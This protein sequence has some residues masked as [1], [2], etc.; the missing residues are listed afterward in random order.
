[1]NHIV[2]WENDGEQ[3]KEVIVQKYPYLN[4]NPYWVAK[5]TEY[6]FKPS[7]TWTATSS[8][9]FGVRHSDAGFV[10]DVAGSSCFPSSANHWALLGFLTSKIVAHAMAFLNPTIEFQ[11]GN[12]ASLPILADVFA[13]LRP[14]VDPLVKEAVGIARDDWNL[15]ETAWDFDLCPVVDAG[16]HLTM[17]YAEAARDSRTRRA[18]MQALEEGI[19][20][21]FI[22]GYGLEDELSPEVSQDAI[23][24]TTPCL[25]KD[26]K[27]LL[28]Y[29]VGCAMG[30]YSLDEPGLIYG[31]SGGEGFDP[32]RYTEF[33]ATDDGVLLVTPDEWFENDAA[34]RF[35]EFA[36]VAWPEDALEENL[37]FVADSLNP[38]KSDTAR[39][40]IRRYFAQGF[41][42]DHLQTYKRRPI[43][44]LFT[45]GKKRA[46][47]ALV[48]LHRYNESTLARMRTAYV[49]PLMQRMRA[50]AEQLDAEH[51]SDDASATRKRQIEKELNA[52]EDQQAE[53][54]AFDEQLQ[55]YAEQQITL[56]L[57]D[58]VK[59]NYGK[60]G[61]LLADVKAVT[62]KAATA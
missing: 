19:N 29:A 14:I 58:G 27:D 3:I 52:L 50:R 49:I 39:E 1:M 41:F 8:S 6:Y 5:N 48:Y 21:A 10:F 26:I 55:H 61:S 4:G 46:F 38:R 11:V 15:S 7:I 47:Q 17:A 60:F 40:T 2:N 22:E 42:K 13:Q 18:R 57:D 35:E 45:S 31:E 16:T 24:L 53:L 25:E 59:I 44:W 28:S 20:L 32:G 30:R 43:Y 54:R 62:G 34:N 23:T 12:V 9:Y 56:D 51:K 33:P 37:T 36:K